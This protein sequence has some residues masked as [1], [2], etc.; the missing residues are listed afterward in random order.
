MR[1]S[2][3]LRE[4]IRACY[5]DYELLATVT[6]QTFHLFRDRPNRLLCLRFPYSVEIICAILT[7]LIRARCQ[8]SIIVCSP[9][10][11]L[12]VFN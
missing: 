11:P 2:K 9:L 1:Q 10:L 4:A 7:D 6:N 5:Y 12:I 3:F 8:I